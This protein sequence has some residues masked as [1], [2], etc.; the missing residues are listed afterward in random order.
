MTTI[1]INNELFTSFHRQL[2]TLG[3]PVAPILG[4]GL[5]AGQQYSIEASC[6]P[7]HFSALFARDIAVTGHIEQITYT[8][9]LALIK[10]F[11]EAQINTEHPATKDD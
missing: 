8:N 2:I 4:D 3:F 9:Y 7:D 10:Q 5:I 1:T 6:G 11:H